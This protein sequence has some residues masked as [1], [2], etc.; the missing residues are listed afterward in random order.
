MLRFGA[1]SAG[2][3]PVPIPNTEVK[4]SRADYTA[5]RETRKVPNYG[6]ITRKSDFFFAIIICMNIFSDVNPELVKYVESTIL[7]KYQQLSGHTGDHIDKVISRSLTTAKD[8]DVNKD[9]VYA[10]AAYHDLGRLVDD[11]THQIESGKMVRKD[12]GLKKFFSEEEIEIIA[13]AVEDHRASLRGD[14][15]SIYG[16]IVSS[17]DR[18]MSV[19][20]M[21]ARSYDYAR[22]L[23]PDFTDDEVIEE[24]RM[25]LREK[26]APGGYGAKKVYFPTAEHIACFKLIDEYTKD[27]LEY[28]ARV[29]EF[30]KKRGLGKEE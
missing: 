10:T 18:N 28:R 2:V 17:A 12:E 21:M 15:R 29:K 14:P 27:P 26:F 22:H 30:N 11:D 1:H 6:K 3:I 25:H 4:P 8:I 24:A 23:P 7:P 13:Q 9:I 5:L 19:D 16:K 20:D